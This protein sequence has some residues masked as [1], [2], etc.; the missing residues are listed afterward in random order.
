MTSSTAVHALQPGEHHLVNLGRRGQNGSLGYC[1]GLTLRLQLQEVSLVSLPRWRIG[2]PGG[3]QNQSQREKTQ[4]EKDLLKSSFHYSAPPVTCT[5][6][7]TSIQPGPRKK[8]PM[9]I[10]TRLATTKIVNSHSA[11]FRSPGRRLGFLSRYG[12]ASRANTIRA[13]A[14]TRSE[15]TSEL[16]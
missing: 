5:H 10:R 12:I 3:R 16:Q 7:G 1:I 6:G 4:R 15:H 8:V 9:T 13:G 11:H 14:T 2:L